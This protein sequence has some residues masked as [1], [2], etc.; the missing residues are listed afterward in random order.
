MKTQ[1]IKRKRTPTAP[2]TPLAQ[3]ITA[4]M[5]ELKLD[6]ATVQKKLDRLGY[7]VDV[8]SVQN[9]TNGVSYPR[10]QAIAPLLAVLK[11]KADWF[12][13]D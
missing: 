2:K 11:Q 8:R 5:A 6:A 7:H 4:R 3:R 9:W 12:F 10:G 1:P 13:Q